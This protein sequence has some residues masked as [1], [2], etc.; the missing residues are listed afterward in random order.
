MKKKRILS[1]IVNK[2]YYRHYVSISKAPLSEKIFTKIIESYNVEL[3]SLVVDGFKIYFY[4]GLSTFYVIEKARKFSL[5]K[6]TKEVNLPVNW[7][8]TNK[9]REYDKD[10]KLIKHF[11]IDD[12]YYKVQWFK[13]YSDYSKK[14]KFIP[15]KD[16]RQGMFKRITEDPLI[17]LKYRSNNAPLGEDGK[18]VQYYDK[19]KYI[20]K[21]DIQN[22]I[23]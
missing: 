18:P 2:D 8:A 6:Y 14:Y 10:G 4:K 3:R 1:D 19:S 5:N 12:Y 15:C 21:H 13:Y 16:F 9:N 11:I 17:R 23:V 22:N 7:S 20:A